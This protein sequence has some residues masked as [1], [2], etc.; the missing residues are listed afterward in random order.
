MLDWQTKRNIR[1]ILKQAYPQKLTLLDYGSF[2]LP[3]IENIIERV[4][5]NIDSKEV[6]TKGTFYVFEQFVGYLLTKNRANFDS[7]L[8]Y[9]GDKGTGK[10]SA[11]ILTAR[12]WCRT[13]DIR[14][15]PRRHVA[16]SNLQVIKALEY[17]KPFEPLVCDEAI[18]FASAQNWNKRENKEL[19]IK[20]G[21]IRTKHLLFILCWPWKINKL[22]KI[23]FESYVNYWV[24]IHTRGKGGLFVKD[25]NPF[26]DPWHISEFKDIGSFTEFTRDEEIERIYKQHPNFWSIIKFRKPS[27]QFYSTYLKVREENVYNNLEAMGALS[28]EDIYRAF[29]IKAFEDVFL[30]GATKSFKRLQKHML[31]YYNYEIKE[32]ELKTIFNDANMIVNKVL[33]EKAISLNKMEEKKDDTNTTV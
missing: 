17:L 20:L 22:D 18:D 29:I 31:E 24:N 19:K 25:T 5:R 30:Q 27:E 21:K 10:S 11:G 15:N 3:E 16:Y 23:Y 7:M 9:T 33:E 14:F 26:N 32:I 1:D 2:S 13:I 8:L 4:L 28:A 6:F 12:E